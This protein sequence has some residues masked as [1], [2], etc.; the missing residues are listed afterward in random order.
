EDGDPSHSIRKRGL[1]QQ[2]KENNWIVN[3]KH[4]AQSPDLNPIEAIW[5]I[6]KQR[7]RHRIFQSEEEIKEALQEEW[8]KVTMTE[9]RK[10]ISQMPRRCARLI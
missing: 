10:R 8:S 4:P 7:L 3:L 6:I 2:L 5:N 1:A 9:V